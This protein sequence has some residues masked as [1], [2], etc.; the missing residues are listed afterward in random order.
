M[1][2]LIQSKQSPVI[3]NV[4]LLSNQAEFK[5]MLVILL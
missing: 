3:K 4:A 5:L 2:F 1:Q